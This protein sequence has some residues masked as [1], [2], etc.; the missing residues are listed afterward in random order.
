[1]RLVRVS[2]VLELQR[3]QVDIDPASE[4]TLIGVYSFGKGIFHRESQPGADLGDYKFS[5]VLPGD[6]I[7]SN[8]QAWE[9]AIGFATDADRGTIGT[10]RFLSYTAR[11][12]DVIDT[13]W[14]RCYFLSSAGFPHIQTAAPG[15]VTRNRTLAQERFEAIE[16]PLPDIDEQRRIADHLDRVQQLTGRMKNRRSASAARA[17]ALASSMATQPHLSDR[18]RR[19]LG[20]VR[21]ALGDV[22]HESSES[23]KVQ[24]DGV[25]PNVGIYSFGRGLFEKPPIEG[26]ETSATQLNRVRAG[27]FI[28]SRLFAFE[29]AYAY[30]PDEF[31]GHYISNE[32]PT[33]DVDPDV[34]EAKF[35][36]AALR[37]PQQWAELA[38]SSKGLGLRRQRIH[39]DALLAYA[40]WF[41]PLGEQRRI[42]AGLREIDR[43]NA[44]LSMSDSLAAAVGPSS[45]NRAFAGLA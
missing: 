18:T 9:G 27:Q 12:P 43:L 14:A 34:T 21:K 38:G 40:I 44:L 32:F 8:I 16:I 17:D 3:R 45:L 31:D 10:H 4:Y 25:Y 5:S 33:F 13:N 26:L 7:L 39:V 2:D 11:D 30:V 19:S 23:V 22:M 37:T 20:W 15:S 24:I 28:Y 29:G 42:V 1:M 35:I 41:P 6:L 36:A